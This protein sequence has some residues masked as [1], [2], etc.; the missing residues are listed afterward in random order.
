PQ[1]EEG[2]TYLPKR[3]PEMGGVF[4]GWPAVR[5]ENLVRAVAPP[6]PGAFTTLDG[7]ELKI[8][9][10]HVLDQM[11]L[12]EAEPGTIL[13]RFPNGDLLVM[14]GDAALYIREYSFPSPE[15]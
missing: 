6:Y 8:L 14:A 4:W 1:S 15:R 2:S 3:T 5:I 7:E 12:F 10:A 13:D 9:R 11:I